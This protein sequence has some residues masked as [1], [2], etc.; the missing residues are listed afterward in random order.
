MDFMLCIMF[1]RISKI[2]LNIFKTAVNGCIY[3]IF[4]VQYSD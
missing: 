3:Q 2:L 4:F 1:K